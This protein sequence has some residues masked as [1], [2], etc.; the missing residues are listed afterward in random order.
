MKIIV[1]L[2]LLVTLVSCASYKKKGRQYMEAGQWEKAREMLVKAVAD[3][4]D[5]AESQIWKAKCED[6]ILRQRILALRDN[7]VA[8]NYQAAL[9]HAHKLHHIKKSWNIKTNIHGSKLEL[10]QLKTL[11]RYFIKKV[12]TLNKKEFPLAAL[13]HI[14]TNAYL[15]SMVNDENLD[16]I[17]SQTNSTGKKQCHRLMTKTNKRYPLYNKYTLAFCDLFEA[18]IKRRPS[19]DAFKYHLGSLNQT[20]S[21]VSY[22]DPSFKGMMVASLE[23]SFKKSVWFQS[24]AKGGVKIDFTI[25]PIFHKYSD[26]VVRSHTYWAKE[27]YIEYKPATSQ[28]RTPYT[29]KQMVCYD[30]SKEKANVTCKQGTANCICKEESVT[31]YK[32]LVKQYSI[33]TTKYRRVQKSYQYNAI[34]HRQSFTL[35]A[36]GQIYL[37]KKKSNFS[38]AKNEEEQGYESNLNIPSISLYPYRDNLTERYSWFKNEISN[39]S[40]SFRDEL[41]SR[42]DEKYCRGS[43]DVAT[44]KAGEKALLCM[45]LKGPEH[46]LVSSWFKSVSGLDGSKAVELLRL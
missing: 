4:P 46:K 43:S 36:N 24:G 34:K 10:E 28:T 1:Y 13:D 15:F 31:K 5:D 30:V 9:T 23:Q 45:K 16:F 21:V 7:I 25:N 22:S 3:D 39:L 42:W 33:P 26:S 12:K 27:K 17:E 44:N 40:N 14:K 41:N 32:T 37:E 20:I 11:Y 35:T 29:V 6:E 19:T 2:L 18:Q 8:G 38:F